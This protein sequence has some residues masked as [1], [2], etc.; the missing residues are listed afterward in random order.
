M[1]QSSTIKDQWM[2][3]WHRP[4][5]GR[6]NHPWQRLLGP[7]EGVSTALRNPGSRRTRWGAAEA[8]APVRLT[9]GSLDTRLTN[10]RPPDLDKCCQREL[11]GSEHTCSHVSVTLSADGAAVLSQSSPLTPR[12][13]L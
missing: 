10:S 5:E 7:G 3:T 13:C 6:P 8:A 9:A 1:L 2:F 11:G 12:E 4:P